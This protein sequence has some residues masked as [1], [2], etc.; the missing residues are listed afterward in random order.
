[1]WG[2][3]GGYQNSFG[4]ECGRGKM[5]LRI[6]GGKGIVNFLFCKYIPQVD[7]YSVSLSISSL[8]RVLKM[9]FK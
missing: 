9:F 3:G 7:L 8:P 4:L 1:M 6:G 5:R 2:S